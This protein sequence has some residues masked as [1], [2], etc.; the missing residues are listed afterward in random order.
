MKN[1]IVAVGL[2]CFALL[3]AS[4]QKDPVAPTPGDTTP[5]PRV[6]QVLP[7]GDSRVQGSPGD[8]ESY[9]YELWKNL[10][11]NGWSVNFIGRIQDEFAYP[12]VNGQTFDPDHEGF[13]GEVSAGMLATLKTYDA[14]LAPDM[15]LIGIGINDLADNISTVDAVLDNIFLA[16]LELRR[17]NPKV[18]IFVEQIVGARS[19]RAING[20]AETLAQFNAGIA[21][22]AANSSTATSQVIAVDMVTGWMDNFMPDQL[23]YNAA[24]AKFVADRYFAAIS[25]NLNP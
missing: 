5:T 3:L 7:L 20:L 24:G 15:A 9:R 8:W 21:D 18:T 14:T 2:A 25:A 10:V 19:D 16:C 13:S 11:T 6:Y 17:L 23:H 22:L 12:L 1:C 4:C